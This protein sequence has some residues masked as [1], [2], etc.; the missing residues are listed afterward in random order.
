MVAPD[1][2]WAFMGFDVLPQGFSALE[3]VFLVLTDV[4]VPRKVS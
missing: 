4:A 2:L 3:W 1:V